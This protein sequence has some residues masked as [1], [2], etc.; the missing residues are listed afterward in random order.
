[1]IAALTNSYKQNPTIMLWLMVGLF[2]SLVLP[3]YGIEDGFF[4]FEW[5][6]D[7]YPVDSDYAP[8][9]FLLAYGEKQWLAPLILPFFGAVYAV[10]LPRRHPLISKLLVLAGGFGVIWL[11]LQGL[12]IGIR[13]WQFPELEALFGPLGDRQFG[14]GY[15]AMLYFASCLFLFSAGI[16]EQRGT[17]GDKFV[18]GMIFLVIMLVAIF[19]FYPILKLIILGFA[20]EKNGYS[21][22]IF[23]EKFTDDRIWSLACVYAGK[24]CGVAWNSVFMAVIVGFLTTALGLVFALIVTRTNLRYRRFIRAISVIPIITPPFVIG[25]AI[26]LLFGLSGIVTTTVSDMFGLTPTRWV[27]GLPGIVI[28]QTLAYTPIAFLVLIGVVESVS[29]SM[30]EAAQTLRASPMQ[31]LNTVSLPLIRPGLANAF[32]LGFIESMADFGNP[33]V[34][35]GN[36]D[37]LSTE[38]FFAIVGP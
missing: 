10:G 28:A 11:C 36:Y 21:L 22:M 14:M 3:W 6:I 29:P 32:L 23:W 7:G 25:L 9:A 2:A 20:D 1:M 37:V 16:A 19:V 38:I 13:G 27:Y 31:V 26:I 15:G 8:L 5:I 30:E 18:I 24:R 4:G 35:G 34:L 17:T 33:L 12:S